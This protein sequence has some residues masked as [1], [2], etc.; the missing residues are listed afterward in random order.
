[1]SDQIFSLASPSAPSEA[2][3]VNFGP[4]RGAALEFDREANRNKV[5]HSGPWFYQNAMLVTVPY[6]RISTVVN[7]PLHSIETCV[8]ILGLPHLLHN[9]KSLQMIRQS[10]GKVHRFDNLAM[11]RKDEKQKIRLTMDTRQRYR[12]YRN[13]SFGSVHVDVEII[14]EKIQGLCKF[15]G[16]FE[17]VV[18]GCDEFF[19]REDEA[20][21][22]LPVTAMEELTI[23]KL[24]VPNGSFLSS[25]V[26]LRA[27]KTQR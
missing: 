12:F 23:A 20:L 10:I 3:H 27:E 24:K 6:D 17:H 2:A 16:L 15:Y 4:A 1:M 5:L 14:Y 26:A 7:P 21:H 18:E 8:L 9:N 13:Y 22:G 11:N 19:V 25:D